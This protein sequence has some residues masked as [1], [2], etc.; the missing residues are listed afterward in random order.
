MQKIFINHPGARDGRPPFWKPWGCGGCLWRTL[1]FLSTLFLLFFLMSRCH[2][3]GN[4]N[5]SGGGP[6][7]IDTTYERP[8]G[9]DTVFHLD[10]TIDPLPADTSQSDDTSW[11]PEHPG[12]TPPTPELPA[13]SANHIAPI[14]NP[15]RDSLGMEVNGN[16]LNVL[17][18]LQQKQDMEEEMVA[19]AKKFKRV[20]PDQ[21]YQVCYY[22]PLTCFMQITVPA[23]KREQVKAEINGKMS[24]FDFIVFDEQIMGTN[25][26]PN[27]P[28]IYDSDCNWWHQGVQL[29]EAWGITVGEPNIIIGVVDSYFDL[30]HP[31]LRTKRIIAPFCLDR[32]NTDPT[33][34]LPPDGVSV[35]TAIHG[36]HVLSC[37]AATANNK[38]GLS[39]IAP[40]CSIIPVSVAD[41]SVQGG[42]SSSLRIAEGILY[43]IMH[44]AH[45]VN[46][47]M[48]SPLEVFANQGED[49]QVAIAQS[50]G[51]EEEK[52]WDYVC[53]VANRRNCMI[54]FAAGND[55]AV[56][57][58]D[59]SKRNSSTLRVS[60]CSHNLD[61]VGFTNYGLLPELGV[62]Y[63]T[64]SM[65]GVDIIGAVPN[66]KY[67]LLD[68]TS[69]AAPLV[70]GVV[71]LMK[72]LDSTLTNDEVINILVET[73]KPQPQDQHIGPLV[74]IKD[75]LERVKTRHPQMSDILNDPNQLVGLWECRSSLLVVSTEEPVTLY[76]KLEPEGRGTVFSILTNNIVHE[77]PV[78]WNVDVAAQKVEIR[79]ITQLKCPKDRGGFK[80]IIL[81]GTA[82]RN[83][84]MKLIGHHEEDDPNDPDKT[85]HCDMAFRN[86]L[87]VTCGACGVVKTY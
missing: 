79:S 74:Q 31:E 42:G 27:D 29:Y 36:T 9:P 59:P 5:N 50:V 70:T 58:I 47:S 15:V 61:S 44:G 65:P 21:S 66:N 69:M 51:L 68:G 83:G 57:G 35:G 17:I 54:V 32:M 45:V 82:D 63:S 86:Q 76:L 12:G 40:L 1:V 7:R 75:A 53:R 26:K 39:G 62:N 18:S 16:V 33:N 6:F 10:P 81:V 80:K 60:A 11:L 77:S 84:R 46:C 38:E 2:G 19:W 13:D 41:P 8:V 25:L 22:N 20:Y 72:S 48:G 34:V 73:G 71:A 30:R 24:E 23:D 28:A 4:S 78:T 52:V 14:D 67:M 56:A 43:C 64:V 37:A 87:T 55:G 49:V 85:F 3:S